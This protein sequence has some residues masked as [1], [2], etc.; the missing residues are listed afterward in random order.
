MVTT[1]RTK[2][3][4]KVTM[5][6]LF[7]GLAGLA[8]AAPGLE[9]EAA[10][11]AVPAGNEVYTLPAEYRS[12]GVREAHNVDDIPHPLGQ[13]RRAL[14]QEAKQAQLTGNLNLLP[15]GKVH[16]VAGGQYVELGLE[17]EDLIWTVLAQFGDVDSFIPF[18]QSP[19]IGPARNEIPQP[20]RSVNNTTI[21][22]SDFSRDYYMDTLFNDADGANSMRNFYKEASSG[23]YAVD[24]DVTEW[25]QVPYRAAHYGREWCGGSVC[26]TTTWW[27][28]EDSVNDWYQSQLA[29][30]KSADEIDAYLSQFDVWDR[31]DHDGDGNFDEADGYIDHFQSVHAGEGAEAGGGAYGSDALW[32]HRWYVQLTPIGAGGPTLDDGTV[33]PFG[34]TQ[35][36]GSKYWIGDYTI[37]PE[38]GGVG[39]FA[40]EFG[41][42][43]GLPDLYNTGPGG[44]NSVGFWSLMASGSWTGD[45]TV[46]IGSKPTHMGGWEKFQLGWLNYEVAVSGQG[47]SVH[48]LGPS[49]FNTKKA[50]ALFVIPPEKVVVSEIGVA[51]EGDYFY[52]SGSGPDLDNTMVRSFNLPANATLSALANV[53]IELDW[54]Y[55]YLIISTDGGATWASVETNLSTTDDPNGQNFGFGI[56]GN[57]GGLWVPLT[58]DLSAYTGDVLLG[59]RYWTDPF[60]NNPG[61]MVDAIDISGS[62]LDGGE[63]DTGWDFVGFSRTTGTE[64]SSHFVAYL[65]EFRGYVGYDDALRTGPYNFGFFPDLPDYVEHYPYQDGLLISLWDTSQEN[66]NTATHPGEGLILPIDAHPEP[67]MRTDVDVPWSAF[68]QSYDSSFSFDATDP[69]T[70]HVSGFEMAYPSLP[71]VSMFNANNSYWSPLTPTAGVDQPKSDTTIRIINYNKRDTFMDVEVR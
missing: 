54:D 63:T 32:S 57:T 13:Q 55:A 5:G 33:V 6:L 14:R 56:T 7:L 29:A 62:P 8:S 20:D 46:D 61:F 48:Q 25:A 38:N 64:T 69:I 16:R 34:G 4:Q 41:H 58:A 23:R 53:D 40:H 11:A 35:I 12:V 27:F 52:Y 39:V 18:L 43:H 68:K 9:N 10:P 36:G 3:V 51:P 24:G 15:N 22:R 66:N 28:I 26:G 17:D 60:V 30:G 2:T 50:Q 44:S 45:G 21:W 19:Q 67:L 1:L 49:E 65:A 37:E 42:D 70:L 31:Y 59:F 71:G 47:I